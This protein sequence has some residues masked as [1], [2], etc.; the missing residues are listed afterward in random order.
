MDDSVSA[1]KFE[2][3]RKAHLSEVMED[4]VEMIADLIEE[5]GEARAVDLAARFGVTSPTVNATIQRLKRDGLVDARPY[6][7]IFLTKE[8]EKL[9]NACKERHQIVHDFLVSI[10]VPSDIADADAEGMEH[11]ISEFTLSLFKKA[12]SR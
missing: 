7:S 4:Y 11:H 3:I 12:I 1:A 8:G 9:A 2:R 6:R 5:T 10:G